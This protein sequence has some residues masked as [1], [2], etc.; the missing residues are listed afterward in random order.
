MSIYSPDNWTF[1]L[2]ISRAL[3]LEIVIQEL[4]FLLLFH[5]STLV[6]KS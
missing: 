1:F 5:I 3:K 2:S 4:L 6:R